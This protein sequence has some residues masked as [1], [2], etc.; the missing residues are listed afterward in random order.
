MNYCIID[1]CNAYQV[2]HGGCA[3]F[4]IDKWVHNVLLFDRHRCS[5]YAVQLFFYNLVSFYSQHLLCLPQHRISCSGASVRFSMTLANPN[6]NA[7]LIRGTIVEIVASTKTV[8]KRIVFLK[9]EV[10]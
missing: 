7:L 1:M 5:C 6:V 10:I 3:A 9:A 8:G 4:L 2:L